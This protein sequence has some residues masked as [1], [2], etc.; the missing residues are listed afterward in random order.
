MDKPA[1]DVELHILCLNVPDPKPCLP[2][3]PYIRRQCH[4]SGIVRGL[5]VATCLGRC[6]GPRV[7]SG[8]QALIPFFGV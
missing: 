1:V 5:G 7:G 6:L 4:I 3:L 2:F 8:F